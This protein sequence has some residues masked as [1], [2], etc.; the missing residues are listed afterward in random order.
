MPIW[1]KRYLK[2]GATVMTSVFDPVEYEEDLRRDLEYEKH[3]RSRKEKSL[4]ERLAEIKRNKYRRLDPDQIELREKILEYEEEKGQID[5]WDE[6]VESVNK[7]T[8]NKKD[9]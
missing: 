9:K 2:L 1:M 4:V 8:L 5:I 7:A 3:L 6:L